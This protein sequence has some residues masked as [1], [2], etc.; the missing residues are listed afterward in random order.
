MNLVTGS[1]I[2]VIF[3]N[4]ETKL[5]SLKELYE[6]AELISDLVLNPPQRISIMRLLICI[7]QGALNGPENEEEWL[8]C[9]DRIIPESLKYLE[10][11][12]NKFNLY[13]KGQPFLQVAGLGANEKKP[14]DKLDFSSPS[15]STL[16]DHEAAAS[17]IKDRNDA[18]KAMNLITL[19]N[20][21]TTG[22]VG[23]AI[24]GKE[25]YNFSTYP[26]PCIGHSHTLLKGSNIKR[27]IYMNLLTK[28]EVKGFPNTVWGEPI[29]DNSPT[30]N[31]DID[32][33]NNASKTYLGRLVPLSR[34]IL[35]DVNDN[36]CIIGPT[37]KT[38]IFE[39][40]PGFREPTTTVMLSKKNEPY[41]L[42]VTSEKH[43]WRDLGAILS[44][45]NCMTDG[46]A[47][48][49]RKIHK[50]ELQN[51]DIWVGGLELGAQAAKLNDMAEWNVSIPL[52]FLSETNSPL[53][54][55]SKGVELADYG[56][57][58]LGKAVSKYCAEMKMENSL[59][60]KARTHFWQ[61]LDNEYQVLIDSVV[62]DKS[63][64]EEWYN[65]IF[66]A[67]NRAFEYA[68]PCVTP[69]QIQAFAQA[70]GLLRLKK[71]E[72]NNE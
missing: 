62:N 45:S 44:L 27:S 63:L 28:K 47:V 41:C 26:T 18:W 25:N 3:D 52:T 61:T 9:K 54:I 22:K 64:D 67:M 42:R 7:T 11:R 35:L 24:W 50:L 69:R 65:K 38:L 30:C 13:D 46:G 53:P 34:L 37:P 12:T 16:F 57:S 71:T 15:A 17:S 49:L 21:N 23:Q 31:N 1:W 36:K 68:C 19:L 6:K 39:G 4:G 10:S 33:F 20:F 5:V 43:I 29:W 40:L 59:S 32:A 72:W 51:V 55:Y 60:T 48:N 56:S 66:A 58:V 2:P 14:L 8:K 70:Q